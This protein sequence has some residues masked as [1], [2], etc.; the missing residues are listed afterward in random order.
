[1]LP[2]FFWTAL[3]EP[4]LAELHKHLRLAWTDCTCLCSAP[5]VILAQASLVMGGHSSEVRS[6]IDAPCLLMSLQALTHLETARPQGPHQ[7]KLISQLVHMPDQ[8]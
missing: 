4:L 7:I 8:L 2:S 3:Y 6:Q 1:M 5:P